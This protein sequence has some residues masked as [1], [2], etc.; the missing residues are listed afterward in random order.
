M[1]NNNVDPSKNANAKVNATTMKEIALNFRGGERMH[2]TKAVVHVPLPETRRNDTTEHSNGNTGDNSQNKISLTPIRAEVINHDPLSKVM[3][4]PSQSFTPK[5]FYP[6]ALGART[7]DSPSSSPERRYEADTQCS[8]GG[9]GMMEALRCASI[10]SNFGEMRLRFV[11]PRSS[12][13]GEDV[14][15]EVWRND[16]MNTNQT[17]L[18]GSLED[19]LKRMDYERSRSRR[20]D[21][22]DQIVNQMVQ[23]ELIDKNS[24]SGVR[25]STS[26][27]GPSGEKKGTRTEVS[28]ASSGPGSV[29]SSS[30]AFA[31]S[32]TMG[33]KVVLYFCIEEIES[34]HLGGIHF[35]APTL[36]TLDSQI[37]TSTPHVYT[38]SGVLGDHQGTRSWIPTIDSASSKHRSSHELTIRVT[39]DSKEGLWAA[40][41]GEHFGVN[42]TV[43]HSFPKDHNTAGPL[44]VPENVSSDSNREELEEV[45]GKRSADF[46]IKRFTPT[47]NIS[48]NGG[49]PNFDKVHIIPPE[50]GPQAPENYQLLA[51]AMWA[52]SIWSPCPSRSLSFAIGPFSIMYDPEYYGRGGDD[53]DDEQDSDEEEDREED[54]DWPTIGETAKKQGE[55]IRQLFFALREERKYIHSG[56][57]NVGEN[58]AAVQYAPSEL[59][60]PEHKKSVLLS[61][62]GSTAGVPNRALSLMRDILSLPSYRTR[63][64]TQIWI[65]DA[66]DGGVSSGTLHACPEISCNSYL[67]G[68]ILDSRLLHPSGHRLPFYAGGR[69]LQFAQARSAIRGWII[70]ALPLGGSDDIGNS[71]LHSLIESFLMSLYERAHGGFGEGGSRHSFFFSK[72][73][74]AS[75]GLNSKNMDFL[76]VTNVEEEDMAFAMAP[77]VGA[78]GALPAGKF[79]NAPT[80]CILYHDQL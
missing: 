23:E 12:V 51:T 14:L 74:A 34:L 50:N 79:T 47:S 39:A 24:V 62:M 9:S 70:S 26:N 20:E 8:R 35:H 42:K 75:S 6:P 27:N 32:T 3:T 53:S 46:I 37:R 72:R 57:T 71:Y 58:V 59:S 41:C 66:V 77:G 78:V 52:S 67:G 30:S 11:C 44:V 65:P 73:Y 48:S 1:N 64:Y 16:L 4:K 2:V 68:A 21:R 5:D 69:V 10:A 38:T 29:K 15:R 76:P 49:C 61:L 33:L 17:G 36:P 63:S 19:E 56:A 54:E 60:D 13:A 80:R 31:G 25:A 28:G 43:L 55:G 18:D 22:L 7:K 45:L 40:G